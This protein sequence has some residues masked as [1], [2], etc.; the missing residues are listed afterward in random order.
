LYQRVV[1]VDERYL[2]LTKLLKFFTDDLFICIF[3]LKRVSL[4][5]NGLN[6]SAGSPNNV[7]QGVSGEYVKVLKKPGI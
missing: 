6:S 4:I 1:E 5:T 3:S 7:F 2:I